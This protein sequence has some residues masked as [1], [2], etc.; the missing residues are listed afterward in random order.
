MDQWIMLD[1]GISITIPLKFK[2]ICSPLHA[3]IHSYL[4]LIGYAVINSQS[5][6]FLF[7]WINTGVSLGCVKIMQSVEQLCLPVSI[8]NII[9]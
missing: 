9:N 7:Y 3:F 2:T 6:H 8:I 5:F 4:D 1:Y